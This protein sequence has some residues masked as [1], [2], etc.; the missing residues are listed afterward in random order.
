MASRVFW[1]LVLVVAAV[2]FVV[3]VL[4]ADAQDTDADRI[5]ALETQVAALVT[6]DRSIGPMLLP[7]PDANPTY[8]ANTIWFSPGSGFRLYCAIHDT[9]VMNQVF[10]LDCARVDPAVDPLAG[11]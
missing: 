5:A 10:A 4:H 9:G 2:I 7:P 8:T 11:R 6:Y 3:A 1:E